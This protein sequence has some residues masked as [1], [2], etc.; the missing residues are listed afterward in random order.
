M[1]ALRLSTLFIFLL[2]LISCYP[3]IQDFYMPSYRGDNFSIEQPTD[4]TCLFVPIFNIAIIDGKGWAPVRTWCGYLASCLCNI[5]PKNAVDRNCMHLIMLGVIM[6]LYHFTFTLSAL[7]VSWM[8][9]FF[10]WLSTAAGHFLSEGPLKSLLIS[11]VIDGVGGVLG[12]VPLITKSTI[13]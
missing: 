10:A 11:G 9:N 8:E 2:L 12:F 13:T 6:G 5:I 3:V 1:R 4:L 7:P